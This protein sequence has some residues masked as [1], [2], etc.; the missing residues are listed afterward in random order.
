MGFYNINFNNILAEL[1]H[2]VFIGEKFLFF[3][4]WLI[5]PFVF[6]INFFESIMLSEL[7][8]VLFLICITVYYIIFYFI[9]KFTFK[10]KIQ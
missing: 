6:F 10:N 2:K 8:F 9:I 3:T 5:L 7:L 4:L 1:L